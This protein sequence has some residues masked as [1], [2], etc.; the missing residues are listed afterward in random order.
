MMSARDW[1][2]IALT[3]GLA[4]PI[5]KPRSPRRF[6][7]NKTGFYSRSKNFER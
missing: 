6:P 7:I 4:Y 2:W 5:L 1:V 3:L